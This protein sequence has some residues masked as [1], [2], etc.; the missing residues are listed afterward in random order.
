MTRT[1]RLL[2]AVS[3][4]ALVALSVTPAYAAGTTAGTEI[5]NT[6]NVTFDVGG[7]AQTPVN[8]NTDKFVVDRKVNLTVTEVGA[9]ATIVTPGSVSQVTTFS[10]TNLSNDTTDYALSVTQQ[11]GGA[12]AFGGGTDTFNATNVRI[13]VESDGVAGFSAGDLNV[14][15][16]GYIDELAA[17]TS[18]TV[19]VV[20]DIPLAQVTGDIATATLTA[21]AYAG[22]TAG[23]LGAL[24]TT[25]ATNTANVVDTVLADGAGAGDSQYDGKFSA[26]DD[27]KVSAAAITAV[28]SSKVIN[29]YVSTSGAMKAI[30]GAL[31]E[32]C[33]LVSNTGS[34]DATNL[35]LKDNIPAAV[36]RDNTFGV[37]LQN[38][39]SDT[40]SAGTGTFTDPG[41]FGKGVANGTV[42]TLAA[43]TSRALVFRA[44]ID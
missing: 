30:P 22:G 41:T 23:S 24:L 4:F 2:G 34:A 14:T 1:S 31:I 38:S 36:T 7:V 10:V 39:C 16:T 5:Q 11:S 27:Y 35:Q 18:K 8:S 33:I 12:S 26:K 21:Q 19:Y 28:K 40:T 13:Y 44:T 15:A 32:Y 17:D 9:A 29:D 20:T 42:A 3:S 6:V 37:K 43:G 25:S